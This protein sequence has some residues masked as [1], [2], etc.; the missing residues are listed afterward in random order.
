MQQTSQRSI[1]ED[2]NTVRQVLTAAP[3]SQLLRNFFT[4]KCNLT[5]I[6]NVQLEKSSSYT[7]KVKGQK[8]ITAITF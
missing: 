7:T 3:N 5:R 4:L 6:W 1:A 8:Q 2:R